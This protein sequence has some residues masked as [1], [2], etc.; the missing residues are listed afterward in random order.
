MGN[1]KKCIDTLFE[2]VGYN[3]HQC[4]YKA[5]KQA[6]Y[7]NAYLPSM[8]SVNINLLKGLSQHSLAKVH[9]GMSYK[10]NV[11]PSRI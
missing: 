1:L 10:L 7:R 9:V 3:C 4:Q 8:I 2:G 6:N 5:V 11:N